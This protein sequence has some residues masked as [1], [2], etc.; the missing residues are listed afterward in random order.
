VAECVKSLMTHPPGSR[1]LKM[2]A[3]RLEQVI[4]GEFMG[5]EPGQR[6]PWVV[7]EAV[8]S[9]YY[10]GRIIG[11]GLFF[12]PLAQARRCFR[13]TNGRAWTGVS[14]TMFESILLVLL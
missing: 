11:V 4:D 2:A 14:Y 9:S 3:H 10:L 12:G 7:V 1:A 13:P 6:G 8:D 5:F